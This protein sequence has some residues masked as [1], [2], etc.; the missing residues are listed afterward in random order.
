MTG[1]TATCTSSRPDG[2]PA[3]CFPTAQDLQKGP[4]TKPPG[5]FLAQ[6]SDWAFI[7][8]AGTMVDYARR[9]TQQHLLRFT[10]LYR[11]ITANSIDQGFLNTLEAQD[12]LF[13]DLNFR[14]YGCNS[15]KTPL[16]LLEMG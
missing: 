14:I 2:L 1:F 3:N 8:K 12:N 9:R 10:E 4:S 6:A 15:A 7:M 13:P 16:P 11:Q 5:N